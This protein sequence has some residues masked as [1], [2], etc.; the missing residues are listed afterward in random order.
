MRFSQKAVDHLLKM[1]ADFDRIRG[2][3]HNYHD[4]EKELKKI[5][6][7]ATGEE[8]QVKVAH[9]AGECDIV[10]KVCR[11]CGHDFK[12]PPGLVQIRKP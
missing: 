9:K 3:P 7:N 2:I 4:L 8:L 1:I 10:D 11:T 6:F 5:D 12:N